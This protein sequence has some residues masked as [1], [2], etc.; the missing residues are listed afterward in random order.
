MSSLIIKTLLL[1]HINCFFR[2]K[3]G[4]PSMERLCDA[5]IPLESLYKSTFSAK[6]CERK[7]G[8]KR[9]IQLRLLWMSKV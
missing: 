6:G 1:T 9:Q 2:Y 8:S 7:T 5:N 4:A 3:K